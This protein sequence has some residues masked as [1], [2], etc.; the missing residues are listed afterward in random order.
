M[1]KDKI[2]IFGHKN[3]DTDSVTSAI[4]LA[5]LKRLLGDNAEPYV[6]GEINL[7]TKFVLN[8]FNIKTPKYLNDVK[9]Q[10]KDLNYHKN[11][12]INEYDS[13]YNTYK[14][15]IDNNVTGVPIVDENNKFLSIVTAKNI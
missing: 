2:Y 11:F 15:M 6:L 4:A 12:Y 9:L 3:P 10:M 7:E 13:L 14:F 8:Y 1:D 5:N